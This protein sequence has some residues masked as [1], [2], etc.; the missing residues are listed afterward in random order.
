MGFPRRSVDRLGEIL[1][2]RFV[3]E[4]VADSDAQESRLAPGD[5]AAL[6]ELRTGELIFHAGLPG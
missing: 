5:G 3:A 4:P 1:P 6:I 2:E